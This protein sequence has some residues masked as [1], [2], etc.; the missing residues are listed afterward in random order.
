MRNSMSGVTGGGGLSGGSSS[1]GRVLI[2]VVGVGVKLL[3]ALPSATLRRAVF[4]VVVALVITCLYVAVEVLTGQ[5]L[6]RFVY[7]HIAFLHPR[8]NKHIQIESGWV[9]YI[10]PWVMNRNIG[11]LNLL[12]WPGLLCLAAVR[13]DRLTTLVATGA[14]VA[15]TLLGTL[16]SAHE[17]S[18]IA[19]V[20]SGLVFLLARMHLPAA[21][22]VVLAGWLA[23]ILAML[24]VV[25]LAYQGGLHQNARIPDTARARIIIWN[26]TAHKFLERPILGVG[27]NASPA[28]SRCRRIFRY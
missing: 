4:A 28:G 9:T 20:L 15:A 16:A 1:G 8:P 27:A 7:N 23:A 12:L 22:T 25:V 17:S 3:P 14:I 11:A 2:L 21:R 6:A 26:F 19:L 5:A 13:R 18:Q 10:G 24:P